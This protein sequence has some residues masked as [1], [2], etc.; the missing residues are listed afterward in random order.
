MRIFLDNTEALSSSEFSPTALIPVIERHRCPPCTLCT[1]PR[2][3]SLLPQKVPQL[4]RGTNIRLHWPSMHLCCS[5]WS[6]PLIIPLCVWR[7]FCFLALC[8]PLQYRSCPES[9]WLKNPHWWYVQNTH[10][11]PLASLFPELF[12]L[13]DLAHPASVTYS[14]HYTLTLV[15]NINCSLPTIS[16]SR[17]SLFDHHLLFQLT[18]PLYSLVFSRETK[19]IDI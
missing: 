10:F 4:Y 14:H 19:P 8:Y 18:F 1:T 11:N 15:D 16:I 6:S 7:V 17:C 9:W 12:L 2:P 5:H 13:V 3:L